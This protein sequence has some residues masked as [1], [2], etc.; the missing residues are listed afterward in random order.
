MAITTYAELQA[1]TANWLVRADLTARIP[2]FIAL[3]EARLNRSLRTRLAESEVSLTAPAGARTIALPGG[4]A[5][6]LA[7]WIVD[8]GRRTA[9]R[10]VEPSLVAAS[11]VAGR[12]GSWGVDGASLAFD[13]PCDQAYGLVLRML[14]KFALSDASPTNG[15]LADG[16]DAYLFATLCEA[17]PFLRDDD[18]A[19]TYEAR[20]A[21]AI[22]ELNAK[23]ARSR[24]ARSL[25]T[26]LP[27]SRGGG[28]DII[29]GV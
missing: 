11:T 29:R 2:E 23:D 7:L 22:G 28:F 15:L 6:P 12:P 14:V 9:M 17:G 20:L 1:A 19:Q 24:A 3:G 18:L 10:L 4:F 26:D 5:E 16:A 8:G 25:V 27:R 21:R 13:R